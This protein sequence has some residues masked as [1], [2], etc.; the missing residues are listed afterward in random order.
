MWRALTSMTGQNISLDVEP[1]TKEGGSSQPTFYPSWWWDHACEDPRGNNFSGGQDCSWDF[2]GILDQLRW[3][4]REAVVLDCDT[5]LEDLLIEASR[6][7]VLKA[8]IHDVAAPRLWN[9]LS[10]LQSWAAKQGGSDAPAL[11]QLGSWSS[12]ASAVAFPADLQPALYGPH[13]WHGDEN[14]AGRYL[15]TLKKYKE[16]FGLRP[17]SRF[18]PLPNGWETDPEPQSWI[19]LNICQGLKGMIRATLG[20]PPDQQRIIFAGKQLKDDRSLQDYNLW[21]EVPFT[22]FWG[23]VA[24]RAVTWE[25]LSDDL[26][27]LE[28]HSSCLTL[29]DWESV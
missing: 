25:I 29:V 8:V 3:F 7:F 4:G 28:S 16:V 15:F 14:Q 18:W 24:A 10:F 26:R 17:P 19:V 13:Q 6:F 20:T 11:A 21:T 9:P 27:D 2:T 12:V 1:W 23:L 5:S 22:W